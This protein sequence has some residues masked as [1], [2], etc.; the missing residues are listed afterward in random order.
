M[1]IE[2]LHLK[3]KSVAF[4][5]QQN[6]NLPSGQ[7]ELTTALSRLHKTASSRGSV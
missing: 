3:K 5:R 4:E 7:T 6:H 2:F 1:V